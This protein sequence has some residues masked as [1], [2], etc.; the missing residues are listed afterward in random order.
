[1]LD[2]CSFSS[3][4]LKVFLID[5]FFY[6]RLLQCLLG[7]RGFEGLLALIVIFEYILACIQKTIGIVTYCAGKCRQEKRFEVLAMNRKSSAYPNANHGKHA[8]LQHASRRK[9]SFDL[10]LFLGAPFHSIGCFSLYFQQQRRARGAL[11]FNFDLNLKRYFDFIQGEYKWCLTTDRTRLFYLKWG[12]RKQKRSEGTK[13]EES[14]V[15]EK[16][17]NNKKQ[18]KGSD[19]KKAKENVKTDEE[20][21][22]EYA[23][24][25]EGE[26]NRVMEKFVEQKDSVTEDTMDYEQM[27]REVMWV[28]IVPRGF[29][30]DCFFS[31]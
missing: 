16:I 5:L 4:I 1:M 17:Q 7:L 19:K 22:G 23:K 27:I 8:L 31:L 15:E 10:K 26:K 9:L 21:D 13:K 30:L 18:R 11:N 2:I 24:F 20:I 12:Q 6:Y 14:C 29:F 3:H 28:R 25:I